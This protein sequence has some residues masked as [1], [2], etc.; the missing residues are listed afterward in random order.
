MFVGFLNS[1]YAIAPL[2]AFPM[3]AVI[4]KFPEAIFSGY[5]NI[6]RTLL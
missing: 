5:N 2:I 1:V 3:S 4:M 6:N